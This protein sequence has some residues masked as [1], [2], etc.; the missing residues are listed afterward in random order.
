MSSHKLITCIVAGRRAMQA[1]ELLKDAGIFTANRYPA[2]G[3][4]ALSNYVYQGIDIVTV[5]VEA[6]RADEIFTRLYTELE[7]D[8]PGGGMIYQEA[9]GRSSEYRLPEI[10]GTD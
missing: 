9:L 2:R 6:T 3:A 4:S 10:E 1:I 5:V 7:M 8:G